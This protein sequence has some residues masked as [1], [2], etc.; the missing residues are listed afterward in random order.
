LILLIASLAPLLP[1][2]GEDL[3]IGGGLVIPTVNPS[4]VPTP[5]ETPDPLDV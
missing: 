5:T 3:V 4:G 1:G 2:C